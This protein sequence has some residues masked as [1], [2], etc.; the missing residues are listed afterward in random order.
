MSKEIIEKA[1]RLIARQTVHQA[2]PDSELFCTLALIDEASYPTVSTITA[3]KAEGL[4]W[5]A[6]CTGLASNKAHRIQKCGRAAVCFNGPEYSI[7]LVGDIEISTDLA[8]K[9]EMW[10]EALGQHFSGPEDSCYCVLLF[11]TKRYKLFV[12]WQ[13]VCGNL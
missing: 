2:T 12:D 6:F 13:E 10:Y 4:N 8:V 9:K 11:K 5:L 3:A 1:I 7:T